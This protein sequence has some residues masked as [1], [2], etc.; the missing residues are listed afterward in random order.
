MTFYLFET[1]FI[2]IAVWFFTCCR[3]WALTVTAWSFAWW[4]WFIASFGTCRVGVGRF[5]KLINHRSFSHNYLHTLLSLSGYSHSLLSLRNYCWEAFVVSYA[6]SGKA[7]CLVLRVWTRLVICWWCSWNGW[8]IGGSVGMTNTGFGS[9]SSILHP[10]CHIALTITSRLAC[11]CS[12]LLMLI[13]PGTSICWSISCWGRLS[14]SL[15]PQSHCQ[16]GFCHCWTSDILSALS[17]LNK[18]YLF[19]PVH[20]GPRI[21]L[22]HTMRHMFFLH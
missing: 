3:L 16:Q 17:Y 12:G 9:L 15:N 1:R 21:E 4:S 8:V 5:S 10:D 13:C 19:I 7:L 11:L 2:F 14:T 18:T 6:Y 22:S 20:I